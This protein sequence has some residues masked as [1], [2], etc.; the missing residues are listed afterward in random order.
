MDKP[1][2]HTRWPPQTIAKLENIANLSGILG[3]MV[4][5]TMINGGY[6]PPNITAGPHL[7]RVLTL[8][9]DEHRY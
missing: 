2:N 4:I 8:P 5:V 1:P 3:L 7:I 9:M 6:D